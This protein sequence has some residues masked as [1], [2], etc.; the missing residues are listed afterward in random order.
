MKC[1]KCKGTLNKVTVTTSPE[2]GGKILS[3]AELTQ[4][5]TV[6]RCLLCNGIWF[7]VNELDQYLAEKLLLLDSNRVP[8]AAELDK[9][10]GVCP[11]CGKKLVKSKAPKGARFKVDRCPNGHGVWLDSTEIDKLENKNFS[12]GERFLLVFRNLKELFTDS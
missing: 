6:D 7:D 9:K 11:T 10:E 5:I 1:C 3:D 8:N 4:E 2:Y 12:F